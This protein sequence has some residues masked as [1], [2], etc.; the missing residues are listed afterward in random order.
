M[1]S[2]VTGVAGSGKTTIAAELTKRGYDARNM[3]AIEGLCSWVDL[4]TGQSDP[5]FKRDSAADWVDRYD[6]L[7]DET[8]L[9]RLLNET[10]DTFF[11]GSSGNQDQFYSQFGKI[12]LLEMD[13]QL[14]RDRVLR[15]KRDHSYGRMPGE[16]E[17][18][19]GYYEKF[20]DKAKSSG[21]TIIDVRKPITEIVGII[22]A[23]AGA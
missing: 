17:A 15:N 9:I 5:N 14:I 3:D 13:D 11:C 23:E 20:Q 8:Q 19:L 10:S 12:F 21:A 16:L 18:I 22:V 2:L 6:W 4:S 1:N 7:W